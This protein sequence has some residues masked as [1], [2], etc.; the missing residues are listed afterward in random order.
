MAAKVPQ[1]RGE[2]KDKVTEEP[3]KYSSWQQLLSLILVFAIFGG[4]IFSLIYKLTAQPEKLDIVAHFKSLNNDDFLLKGRVLFK[5]EPVDSALVW[6]ILED[7]KR[8]K[9]SPPGEFTDQYGEF[10]IQ[11]D[12]VLLDKV[13]EVTVHARADVK[14]YKAGLKGE[15]LLLGE[16]KIK[17]ELGTFIIFPVMFVF[18]FIVPFLTLNPRSKYFICIVSAIVFAFGIIG[19]VGAGLYQLES[20]N[21]PPEAELDLGFA[22]IIYE[23]YVQDVEPEWIFTLSSPKYDENEIIISSFG[24]PL[25][26]LLL[27]VVGAA[28]LTVSI[29]VQEIKDRPNFYLLY[30]ILKSEK[31]DKPLSDLFYSI[32]KRGRKTN[33][34]AEQPESNEPENPN[35]EAAQKELMEFRGKLERIIRHQFQI[36]FSPIGAIFVYQSLVLTDAANNLIAV[37]FAAFGAGAAISLILDR[38]I[39]Y[40]QGIVK[41]KEL[42]K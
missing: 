14:S 38:A 8:N 11:S 29:V 22:S 34:P 40:A 21:L 5:G 25:W 7:D 30:S 27:S 16:E 33:S 37:G 18:S 2:G 13:T 3:T 26:I 1:T 17:L 15:D 10:E 36:L 35:Q 31:K 41:L 12:S 24:V 28:V 20:M 39:V 6:A 4:A 19:V 9:C 23:T 32:L 42:E